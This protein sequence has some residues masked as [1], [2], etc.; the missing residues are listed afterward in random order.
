MNI[1][2]HGYNHIAI[3]GPPRVTALAR[4]AIMAADVVLIP[5]Q[6]SP[7]NIG[8]ADEVGELI[9]EV[10]VYK[11][12]LKAAFWLIVKSQILRLGAM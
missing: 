8:A 1:I 4:P 11:E 12:R 9:D 3:D 5:V 2:G 7:Y 6:P 10:R